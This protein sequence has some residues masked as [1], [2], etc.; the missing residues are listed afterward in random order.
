[1]MGKWMKIFQWMKQQ[2]KIYLLISLGLSRCLKYIASANE[3][4]HNPPFNNLPSAGFIDHY[5]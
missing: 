5:I 3:D 2:N 1:M 4:I